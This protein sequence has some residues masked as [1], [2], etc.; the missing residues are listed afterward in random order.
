MRSFIDTNLLVYADSADE[1]AKQTRAVELIADLLRSR[2]G[3][4]STQV[5][6]EFVNASIRKLGLPIPLV[7]ERIRLYERFEIVVPSADAVM[8]ALD[9]HVLHQLSYWDALIVQAARASGCVR[10]LTEDLHGGAVIGGIRIVNPFAD[11]DGIS[12]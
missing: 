3:V 10:I 5:L 11:P 2:E 7:R 12:A 9:L 8:Q 6:H 4:I 1:P